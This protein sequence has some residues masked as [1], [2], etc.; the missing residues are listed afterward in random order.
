MKSFIE[1]I[2]ESKDKSFTDTVK[3]LASALKLEGFEPHLIE[4]SK[5]D[6][7]TINFSFALPERPSIDLG[8]IIHFVYDI[9]SN[10]IRYTKDGFSAVEPRQAK[11]LTKSLKKINFLEDIHTTGFGT[12]ITTKF[13]HNLLTQTLKPT[14]KLKATLTPNPKPKVIKVEKTN[15]DNVIEALWEFVHTN[16]SSTTNYHNLGVKLEKALKLAPE[17]NPIF[18]LDKPAQHSYKKLPA[19]LVSRVI[20]LPLPS[21]KTIINTGKYTLKDNGYS[22]WGRV[23]DGWE[24]YLSNSGHEQ[25]IVLGASVSNLDIVAYVPGVYAQLIGLNPPPALAHKLKEI[26]DAAYEEEIIVKKVKKYDILYMGDCTTKIIDII[27]S[28]VD[29]DDWEEINNDSIEYQSDW[30]NV[31]FTNMDLIHDHKTALIRELK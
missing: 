30:F 29:E 6:E 19:K 28:E 12:K 14:T 21:I 15:I 26:H 20:G 16:V 7:N 11:A 18:N 24:T 8:G 3:L 9:K 23:K 4:Q 25:G 13:R 2:T 1:F 27:Q 22:S 31:N 10:V 17:I 5:H